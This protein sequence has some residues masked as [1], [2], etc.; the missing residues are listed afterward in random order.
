MTIELAP[1]EDEED[2]EAKLA[3]L[4]ALSG[5]VRDLV[6][7]VVLTDVAESEITA[8]TAEL[9]ALTD[10]LHALRRATPRSFELGP[11]GVPRHAGNAVTGSANPHAL[12]LVI[13][14]TPERTVRAELSF[15]PTHEGPPGTVHGGVSAMILDH[16]L[17]QAVAVAGFP[18]MT[19]TLTIRYRGRVPYGEPL[20]AT[21][22][23]TRS[24][25]RKNW[26]DGRIALPG[27]TVLVEATGLF[28]TPSAWIEQQR[29]V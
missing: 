11:D 15:R 22:E 12:P 16:L 7:A 13:E 9:A 21:A 20:L 29:P 18:G 19:G 2:A 10:R 26:V 3:A 27:G 8:V 23:H 28:I 5:Q 25:G 6:D 1:A 24:E 17:G 4:S 14:T